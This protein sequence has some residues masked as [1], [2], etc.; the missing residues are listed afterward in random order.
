MKS[1]K[2]IQ[3]F[4]WRLANY[5]AFKMQYCNSQFNNIAVIG[6]YFLIQLIVLFISV[7]ITSYTIL[8][9]ALIESYL[10]SFL[11]T[12]GFYIWIKIS[13][14]IHHIHTVRSVLFIQLFLSLVISMLITMPLC[15][16]LFESEIYYQLF[17]K[18]GKL[19]Y[20]IFELVWLLP[21]G[22]YLTFLSVNVGAIALI[23]CA[24]IYLLIFFLLFFPYFLIF[25]NRRSIYHSVKQ[26]YERNF[27]EK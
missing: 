12:C 7:F 14:G 21:Y 15:F 1:H 8:H 22:L 20:S 11:L 16:A 6:V 18:N 19:H 24:T 10:I 27:I 25:Q 13:T 17:L 2:N 3:A 23:F 26:I 5:D 9:S 4:F